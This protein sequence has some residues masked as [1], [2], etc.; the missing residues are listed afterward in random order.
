[1]AKMVAMPSARQLSFDQCS[2]GFRALKSSVLAPGTEVFSGGYL[3]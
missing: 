2:G 3:N 1:M